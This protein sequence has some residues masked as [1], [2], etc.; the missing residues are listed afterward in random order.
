M[1][2][3][4]KIIWKIGYVFLIPFILS[5]ATFFYFFHLY[6]PYKVEVDLTKNTEP[7]K[8][9]TFDSLEVRDFL[10][11]SMGA[12][13]KFKLCLRNGNKI[14][15]NNS[16]FFNKY[17]MSAE[18][19]KKI[20]LGAMKINASLIKD[21]DFYVKRGEWKCLPIDM[22]KL[23]ASEVTSEVNT[24]VAV[25]FSDKGNPTST[26]FPKIE[27]YSFLYIRMQ[28]NNLIFLMIAWYLSWFGFVLLLKQICRFVW[29][30]DIKK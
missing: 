3:R 17:K 30:D 21:M 24:G 15:I 16:E 12:N 7:Y 18:D 25:F 26:Q 8:K 4:D 2:T 13:L 5:T 19:R 23:S 10:P 20:H 11:N 29:Q 9:I 6:K 22:I 28:W 1:S 27:G 14:Y